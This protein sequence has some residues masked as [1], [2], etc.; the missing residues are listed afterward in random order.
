MWGNHNGERIRHR[1]ADGLKDDS[2]NRTF[3][4]RARDGWG[5]AVIAKQSDVD[6]VAQQ[7][8]LHAQ[9]LKQFRDYDT[10]GSIPIAYELPNERDV[11]IAIDNA[12]GLRVRN[13]IGQYPR[14][15]GP[16]T[17]HWDGLDD[18][19][20]PVQ[21]GHYTATVLHH[22][23][24]EMKL[25]NSVYSSSTPP[26]DTEEGRKLWGSNHGH[27]TAV[28]IRGDVQTVYFNSTEGGSGIIR[29]D[30]QGIIQWADHNEMID[31]TIGEKYIY[32]LSQNMWQNKTLL[33][34]FA[35]QNGKLTP[36]DDAARTPSPTLLDDRGIPDQPLH[37]NAFRY[38]QRF[39]LADH[40]EDLP[41]GW[42]VDSPSRVAAWFDGL[43]T[44]WLDR[45]V[46]AGGS[47]TS[48]AAGPLIVS[49]TGSSIGV[50]GEETLDSG[51]YEVWINGS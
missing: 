27:P 44:R 42:R 29:I 38:V 48:Q 23:P 10:Y 39:R 31:G 4:F 51:R 16:V 41:E 18:Q 40:A 32:G 1:L 35:I 26:W 14:E 13:L 17:D 24:V 43:M 20:N 19:G 3:M 30:D 12:E 6:I 36:F 8:Q 9:R 37:G 15:A 21:P 34:R 49:F 25:V 47:E 2:T 7:K 5:R 46:V 33:F 11:T 45:V 22:E 50:F 28:A